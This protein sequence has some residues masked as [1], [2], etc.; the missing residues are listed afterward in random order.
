MPSWV[1]STVPREF[2]ASDDLKKLCILVLYSCIE[3]QLGDWQPDRCST[4]PERGLPC[5]WPRGAFGIL[6]S[7]YGEVR[8]E[9]GA[10]DECPICFCLR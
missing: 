1:A 3:S 9:A 7:A 2:R 10:D 4:L 6:L 5:S 8:E